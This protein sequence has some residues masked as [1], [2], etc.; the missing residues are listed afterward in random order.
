MKVRWD[1]YPDNIG[2]LTWKGCF[3]CHDEKHK[4]KAGQVISKDC[5]ACHIIISQGSGEE[6]AV[7]LNGLEF[8]HPVDIDEAWKEMDCHECHTGALP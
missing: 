8:K 6:V 3:R 7:S 5:N 2:H 1:V 4:T